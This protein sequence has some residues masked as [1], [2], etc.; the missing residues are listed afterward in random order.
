MVFILV[1][2]DIFKHSQDRLNG[3]LLNF[4]GSLHLPI[5]IEISNRFRA[6][7]GK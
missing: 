6:V 1:T 7:F 5:K 2:Q 3:I 4:V